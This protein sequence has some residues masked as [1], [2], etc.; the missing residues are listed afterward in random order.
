MISQISLEDLVVI[1]TIVCCACVIISAGL[2][3]YT[4]H[5]LFHFTKRMEIERRPYV[6]RD[7][8]GHPI[9]KRK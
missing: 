5:L 7:T 1:L 6:I 9:Y 2:F 4:I 8:N 3:V